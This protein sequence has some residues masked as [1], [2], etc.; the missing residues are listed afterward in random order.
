MMGLQIKSLKEI[1]HKVTGRKSKTSLKMG[2]KNY[3]LTRM[4]HRGRFA[5]WELTFDL[6]RDPPG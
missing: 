4:H 2:D 5:A 1:P 6:Q 3:K